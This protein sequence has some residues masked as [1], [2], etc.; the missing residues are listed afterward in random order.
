MGRVMKMFLQ[1]SRNM[2]IYLSLV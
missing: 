1:M 2:N